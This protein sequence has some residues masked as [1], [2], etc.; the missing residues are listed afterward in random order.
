MVNS[1]LPFPTGDLVFLISPCVTRCLVRAGAWGDRKVVGCWGLGGMALVLA[2]FLPTS[3]E[4]SCA[5]MALPLLL[6]LRFFAFAWLKVRY[7]THAHTITHTEAHT[8]NIYLWTAGRPTPS[9]SP[10]QPPASTRRASN[11][12]EIFTFWLGNCWGSFYGYT[13]VCVGV[14]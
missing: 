6:P 12:R 8:S 13:C 1:S 11:C 9:P 14:V 4:A 7:H 10:P 5:N 2:Y 3:T